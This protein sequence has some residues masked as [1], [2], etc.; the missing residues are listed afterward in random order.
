MTQKTQRRMIDGEPMKR[1]IDFNAQN[2][3]THRGEWV[4]DTNNRDDQPI[5]TN[6]ANDNPHPDGQPHPTPTP[7]A[8]PGT[9]GVV[10]PNDVIADNFVDGPITD[11][12]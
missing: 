9:L 6:D 8:E 10:G 7:D 12:P 1:R 4:P 2:V 5:Q 11:S 3:I